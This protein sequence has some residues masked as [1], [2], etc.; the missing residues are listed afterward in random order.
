ME[1][2]HISNEITFLLASDSSSAMPNRINWLFNI[3]SIYLGIPYLLFFWGWLRWWLAF[4]IIGLFVYVMVIFIQFVN[5]RLKEFPQY[6]AGEKQ[7]FWRDI[8]IC[9]LISLGISSL[10]GAGGVGPQH[11]DYLKHNAVFKH[12]IESSWP[13]WLETN[14]GNFPLV[15]YTA[16][17]LPAALVGKWIGWEWGHIALFGWTFLG[18]FLSTAWVIV[19]IK[20][21]IL[22]SLIIFFLFSAPESVGAILLKLATGDI[23]LSQL[24]VIRWW[25]WNIR[26][27]TGPCAW[28]YGF[29]LECL[30]WVP[31]QTLGAWISSGMMMTGY[32]CPSMRWREWAMVPVMLSALWSPLI[33][34]GLIPFLIAEFLEEFL[35]EKENTFAQHDS[36]FRVGNICYR[37]SADWIS[38]INLASLPI[39]FLLGFYY[40]SR[41]GPLPFPEHPWAEFRFLGFSDWP[42]SKY[43]FRLICFLLIEVIIIAG[44][45]FFLR[46]PTVGRERTLFI[47]CISVLLVLPM[48]RYGMGNDL[49]MRVS[50]PSLFILSI[51]WTKILTQKLP[52]LRRAIFAGA[53][54]IAATSPMLELYYHLDSILT[55]RRWIAI[56]PIEE[57]HSLWELNIKYQTNGKDWFFRQYIGSP[58]TIFFQYLAPSP[59]EHLR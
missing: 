45:I 44:L 22:I 1:E 32:F 52:F 4:P 54:I 43:L 38:R 56:P 53:V 36:R 25:N 33:T 14:R 6:S 21:R 57:V 13:V 31:H 28:N 18:I 17:Y 24:P 29:H 2:G 23:S 30:F 10:S 12:L 40:G 41:F 58:E 55:R 37:I 11:S 51:F 46:P 49:G 34:L 50:M 5:Q 8:G 7:N 3:S 47:A 15:Y 19:L 27:W 48:F 9:L 59:K 35:K 39:L 16:W 20:R 42:M 26:W